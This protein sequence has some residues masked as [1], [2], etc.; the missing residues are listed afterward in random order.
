MTNFT[1]GLWAYNP[2][3]VKM[4][5]ILI[6]VNSN[7]TIKFPYIIAHAKTGELSWCMHNCHLIGSFKSKLDPVELSGRLTHWPLGDFNKILDK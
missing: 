2:N 1:K 7:E 4:A 6:F 3:P 5:S